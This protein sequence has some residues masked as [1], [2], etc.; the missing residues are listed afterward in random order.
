MRIKSRF[1]G[2]LGAMLIT[3]VSAV[4]AQDVRSEA[5]PGRSLSLDQ[6]L[7]I[8]EDRA[9]QI[10]MARAGITR[11]TADHLRT[12]SQR[13]PQLNA[14]AAY[15]R[16]LRSEFQGVFDR[17]PSGTPCAPLNA[18]PSAPLD[19]RITE[20]ERFLKCGGTSSTSFGDF[21]DLPF[22]RSN[23]YRTSLSFS[24]LLYSGGRIGSQLRLAR[25]ARETAEVTLDSARAQVRLDAVQAYFDAVLSDQL[26][27]IA[28]SGLRQAEDTLEQVR[29]ARSVG[30]QPEFEL[31]RAQVA[32]DNQRPA[33]I[34]RRSDR[35]IAYT[36][37]RQM[38][39]LPAGTALNLTTQ[40]E[41]DSQGLPEEFKNVAEEVDVERISR[42]R[43]PI[44]Q[45]GLALRMQ[46][47]NLQVAKSQRLPTIS[48]NSLL[49][50]VAYPTV[51]P[52]PGDFRTNW[53]VGLSLQIP[54]LDG[55]RMQAD[56][57]AAR[58][59]VDEARAR[60]KQVKDQSTLDTQV[61]V[62]QLRAAR[63]TWEA[64]AGTV[65]QAERAYQIA[66]VRYREGIS[67]QLELSDSRLLLEQARVNRAQA[68]RD[69]Q[70][71]RV[72]VALL[73]DLPLAGVGFAGQ[74]Q[75]FTGMETT[76]SV[77]S[78]PQAQT[79]QGQGTTTMPGTT[80]TG[81]FQR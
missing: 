13:L 46:E 68:A 78:Q 10:E 35:A 29:V 54:L 81:G 79:G 16:T 6:A 80:G 60:L 63:A 48:L 38:L 53:T 49:S 28:E 7:Q 52:T 26:L 3:C 31:L 34:R 19:Q 30:A 43:A 2:L 62:E 20:L 5:A 33:V 71:A 9:E 51:V 11:A 64:S 39:D 42:A 47:A 56:Q 21:S 61:A 23:I 55:G 57:M 32:R 41:G 12:R 14:G 45:A 15:D 24:Q 70:V 27:S 22:G 74:T 4:I 65:G 58:A 50:P 17:A 76:A 25:A 75:S 59:N 44:L 36:R 77:S 40:L 8:A 72:R 69:L 67:T 66:E 73:P 1:T 18:D 37:L